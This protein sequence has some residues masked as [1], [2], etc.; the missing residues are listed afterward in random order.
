[1]GGGI[2][3]HVVELV[4]GSGVPGHVV[5]VVGGS[6]VLDHVVGGSGVPGLLVGGSVLDP[7][8]GGP[9]LLGHVVGVSS[10]GGAAVRRPAVCRHGDHG[11]NTPVEPASSSTRLARPPA[12]GH[13]QR[14]QRGGSVGGAL[15]LLPGGR[16]P[17]DLQ[18]TPA[19]VRD[20]AHQQGPAPPGPRQ[21]DRGS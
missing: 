11:D 18:V 16:P 15:L 9:G 21:V 3:G 17:A 2:P 20:H 7:V 10:P 12:A 19:R 5:G 14:H 8:M 4:G 13:A 6:M 1:M